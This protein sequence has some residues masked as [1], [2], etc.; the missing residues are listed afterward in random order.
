MSIFLPLHPTIDLAT[1]IAERSMLGVVD[2][3][4]APRQAALRN[5]ARATDVDQGIEEHVS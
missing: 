1:H 4:A 3:D 2:P 5:G